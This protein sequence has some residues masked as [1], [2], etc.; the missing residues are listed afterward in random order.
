MSM[1]QTEFDAFGALLITVGDYYGKKLAP[2]T[3]Q[4]YWNA[5]H[6][7]DFVTVKSALNQHVQLSKF[8]PTIS[9]VLDAVR[10][11]DGRPTPEEAWAMVARSLNDEGVTIVWTEEMAAAF[12]IALGLQ[13]DRVAARM[14]FKE[15]YV[16]A[17][18]EARG[19]GLPVKWT[20]SLGT[21]PLGREGPLVEAAKIGRLPGDYVRGLLPYQAEPSKEIFALLSGDKARLTA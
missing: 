12:G 18:Q 19:Q 1:R 14:A 20:A 9:E 7:L 5:L 6:K 2:A 16:R 4:L 15:T 13:E 21:N 10:V 3:V 11:M 17:V 8:M